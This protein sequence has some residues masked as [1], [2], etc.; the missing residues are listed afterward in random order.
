MTTEKGTRLLKVEQATS[1]PAISRKVNGVSRENLKMPL[2]L[3]LASG[4]KKSS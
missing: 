1:M 3:P 4:K 2:L